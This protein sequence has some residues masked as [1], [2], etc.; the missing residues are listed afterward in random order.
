[1]N[2]LLRL[3]RR[4]RHSRL[5]AGAEPL[6]ALARPVYHR[7]LDPAGRGVK[8]RVGG[9]AGLEIRLPA[10]FTN[11]DFSGYEPESVRWVADWFRKRPGG[12]FIDVG[13]ANGFFCSVAAHAGAGP[14]FALDSDAASLLA[15]SRFCR[16]A[17]G[18]S[19]VLLRMFASDRGPA[20]TLRTAV[21]ETTSHLDGIG[22]AGGPGATRYRCIGGE[23]ADGIPHH[24]LDDVFLDRCTEDEEPVLLKCDVEGAE[25][26]VLAG[27]GDLLDRVRP[28]LLLSVHPPALPGYGSSPEL[29]AET[30]NRHGYEYEVIAVDHEEHWACRPRSSSQRTPSDDET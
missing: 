5:L 16:P 2:V 13:C 6:W 24:R 18:D 27:A 11:F 23:G 4:V 14:V 19:P 12:T 10:E 25:A 8:I 1:M 22:G 3:A 21:A 17:P 7:A 9:D 20:V 28:S 30:L 29:I 26:L 15:A